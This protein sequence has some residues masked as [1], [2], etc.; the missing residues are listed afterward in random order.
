[1]FGKKF[2]FFLYKKLNHSYFLFTQ[3]YLSIACRSPSAHQHSILRSNLYWDASSFLFSAGPG[4]AGYLTAGT[5][6]TVMPSGP[7][8]VDNDSGDQGWWTCLHTCTA[9]ALRLPCSFTAAAQ[10]G[11]VS[12]KT[13]GMKREDRGSQTII[14][15][16]PNLWNTSCRLPLLSPYGWHLRLYK[17]KQTK[18]F[19]IVL[20]NLF[21]C[22]FCCFSQWHSEVYF[23]YEYIFYSN[24]FHE[25]HIWRLSNKISVFPNNL[26]A[27]CLILLAYSRPKS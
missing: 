6:T 18:N 4:V 20:T 19:E 14:V 2:I 21:L 22:L 7:P 25:K 24:F 9:Q 3:L 16:T 17:N 8:P 11:T 26:I 5:S 12:L 10:T 15:L 27:D 23:L 1:M 13:G